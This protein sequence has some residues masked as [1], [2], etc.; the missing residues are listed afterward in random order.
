MERETAGKQCPRPLLHF[1]FFPSIFS[2]PALYRAHAHRH[3]STQQ[4]HQA[5]RTHTHSGSLSS[6]KKK[7]KACS[8]STPPYPPT[9]TPTRRRL[10]RRPLSRLLQLLRLGAPPHQRVKFDG[11]APVRR[12]GARGEGRQRWAAAAIARRRQAAAVL[13]GHHHEPP[14]PPC[15][16]RRLGSRGGR[17]R[18][19]RPPPSGPAALA[20][21]RGC[22]CGGGRRG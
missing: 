20:R 3:P 21:R 18:P 16:G 10:A 2:T 9:P 12:I 17:G 22:G 8:S 13:L 5:R 19:G 14:P 11:D 1:F 4:A 15:P 6:G 7:N